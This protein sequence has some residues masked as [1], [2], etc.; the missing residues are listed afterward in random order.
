M[1]LLHEPSPPAARR[2][3]DPSPAAAGEADGAVLRGESL[4]RREIEVVRLAALGTTTAGIA[5]ALHIRVV[6]AR[7][8][9][10]NAERKL[11]ARSR[12]EM[13]LLAMRAGLV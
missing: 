6:T 3:A 5:D 8:H 11:G 9:I 7:N 12:L 1:H 2:P 4:T 13:V 10:A